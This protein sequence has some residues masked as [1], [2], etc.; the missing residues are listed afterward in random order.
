MKFVIVFIR[1]KW[2]IHNFGTH[3]DHDFNPVCFWLRIDNK[4]CK[5]CQQV[6]N[7][8]YLYIYLDETALKD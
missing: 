7:Y 3:Y 5:I 1:L 4:I 6:F 2:V 8:K